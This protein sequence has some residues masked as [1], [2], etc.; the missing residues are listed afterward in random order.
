MLSDIDNN[1]LSFLRKDKYLWHSWELELYYL[2]AEFFGDEHMQKNSITQIPPEFV[3]FYLLP[4]AHKSRNIKKKK[5]KKLLSTDIFTHEHI[6]SPYWLI[7]G[8]NIIHE[9]DSKIGFHVVVFIVAIIV[10]EEISHQARFIYGGWKSLKSQENFV[11]KLFKGWINSWNGKTL[12][13]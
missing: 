8:L 5:E 1:G 13:K 11:L 12:K 3:C 9:N 2:K 4:W 6:L 7:T 10:T